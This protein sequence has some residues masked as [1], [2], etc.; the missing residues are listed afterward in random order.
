MDLSYVTG[1][2]EAVVRGEKIQWNPDTQNIT[3]TT[4]SEVGSGDQVYVQFYDNDGNRAGGVYIA[5]F[6]QITYELGW[7]TDF[8]AFR[9]SVPSETYKTWTI[10]YNIAKRTVVLY[11][12]DIKVLNVVVS[13]SECNKINWPT[14]WEERKP[15]QIQ[16][17]SSSDTASDFYCFP[18]K[19]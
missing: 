9:V 17:S 4:D 1:T 15:E 3:V 8:K 11:C 18:A 10:T 19:G 6:E 2:L 16:F 12:N 14:Y 13:D 7:C 5:F